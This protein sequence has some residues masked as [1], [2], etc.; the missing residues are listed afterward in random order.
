[1]TRQSLVTRKL[2]TDLDILSSQASREFEAPGE[3]ERVKQLIADAQRKKDLFKDIKDE[4]S[5]RKKISQLLHQIKES[6]I[7]RNEVQD[8]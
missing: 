6:E 3:V 5:A 8:S 7:F 4:A 1:M 2:D